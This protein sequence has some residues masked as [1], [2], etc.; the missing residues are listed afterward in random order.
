MSK[1]YFI[2][3]FDS[4]FTQVEA[5]DELARISLQDRADKEEI[6]KKIEDYTNQA[7]EGKLSFRES[8][9]ARVKLLEADKSHLKLLV[10]H[11]K[12][13]VSTS[14]ARNKNFFK[15]HANEVLIVSGGFKEFIAPVVLPYH[16]KSEN[17]YANTFVF[18]KQ[19]KIIGY[20]DTNP[21]S[22]EG[23]KVKLLKELKLPGEIHGIGD[24]YSDFQLKE[25]G[26]IK[27]F[28]AFTENVERKSVT[29]R[30]DHI[31]PSLD[32]VLFI[33]KIPAA[34]SYPKNR[35]VCLVAGE[36][37][38]EA[39]VKLLKKDGFSVK[40]VSELT[41]ASI[42]EAGILLIGNKLTLTNELLSYATK[43]KVI[44]T[45]EGAGLPV[46]LCTA[47]GVAIFESGKKPESLGKRIAKYINNGDTIKSIN[48]P[49]LQLPSVNGHR[50]IHIH[51]NVPGVLAKVNQVF[52]DN[53]LN[54]T[55]QYLMTNSQIGYVITDISGQ[56]DKQ[57]LKTMKSIP[58]TIQLRF[59][60]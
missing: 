17:I 54:I 58:H 23:G 46:E 60:Y 32:E 56:Y 30:A 20:D 9:A 11:L 28:Y 18:D 14:F 52:A 25:S 24:G 39:S 49:H 51:Q 40:Q 55:A 44:G 21:L 5:L 22:F 10:K 42:A 37:I 38:P 7:M 27:K 47:H 59:L 57:M 33:N 43:L 50:F 34:I 48:F 41:K 26:M 6:Y 53:Q 35:I 12:T 15:Q 45:A 16:I 2:I 4:T 8:L 36:N 31:T 19:G 29:E 1:K 13:L 3:D